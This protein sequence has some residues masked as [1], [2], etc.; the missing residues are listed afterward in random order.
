MKNEEDKMDGL[1]EELKE[2][3]AEMAALAILADAPIVG[4]IQVPGG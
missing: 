1:G 3:E 4:T 2:L